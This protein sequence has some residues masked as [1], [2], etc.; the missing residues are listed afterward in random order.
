MYRKRITF[1]T[2]SIFMKG[3]HLFSEISMGW[4]FFMIHFSYAKYTK[5]ITIY[6]SIS[7]YIYQY[8]L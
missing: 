3:N 4:N 8:I 2:V 5:Y 6:K 1:Y 7:I